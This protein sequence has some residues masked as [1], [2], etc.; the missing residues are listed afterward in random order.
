MRVILAAEQ[1][2]KM[3]KS[4]EIY[5]TSTYGDT[6]LTIAGSIQDATDEPSIG[7]YVQSCAQLMFRGVMNGSLVFRSTKYLVG[8]SRSSIYIN[9]KT[10]NTEKP[11]STAYAQTAVLSCTL[12][13]GEEKLYLKPIQIDTLYVPLN[14]NQQANFIHKEL[15][16]EGLSFKLDSDG[17]LA[18]QVSK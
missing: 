2:E 14:S 17:L 5:T 7:K 12:S 10:L 13:S 15:W 11:G 1:D 4:I 8:F 6:V 9:Q 3:G 16:N 18:V